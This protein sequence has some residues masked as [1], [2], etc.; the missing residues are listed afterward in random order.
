MNI[1]V[2]CIF[3]RSRGGLEGVRSSLQGFPV[4]LPSLDR[5]QAR[6][7]QGLGRTIVGPAASPARAWVPFVKSRFQL[8]QRHAPSLSWPPTS[9]D[10]F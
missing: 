1:E 8:S 9:G 7:S 3:L 4:A 5:R 2:L 10:F 6:A